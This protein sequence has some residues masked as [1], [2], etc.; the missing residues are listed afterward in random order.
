MKYSMKLSGVVLMILLLVRIFRTI[1]FGTGGEEVRP[2]PLLNIDEMAK[3]II[4]DDRIE[5]ET[6]GGLGNEASPVSDMTVTQFQLLKRTIKQVFPSIMVVPGLSPGGTDS[7]HFHGL[8]SNIYRFIPFD[9]YQKEVEGIH[10]T[11]EKV[12]LK[13]LKD[14]IT[15]YS[16][17]IKNPTD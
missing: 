4:N 1:S 5:I 17:L 13:S 7:K 12:T 2:V 11:N 3:R 8:T 15:F 16:Q 14:D 6:E 9:R 10:G